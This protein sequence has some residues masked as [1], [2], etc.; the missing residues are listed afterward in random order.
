MLKTTPKML[1]IVELI[2]Y[3]LQKNA[4]KKSQ[5]CPS[6]TLC[7]WNSLKPP[8]NAQYFG[9]KRL[10]IKTSKFI[11]NSLYFLEFFQ[12]HP[13]MFAIFEIVR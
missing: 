2:W 1:D 7:P 9:M 11:L 3:F 8:K 4:Y 10:L 5:S 12:N 6:F 13:K